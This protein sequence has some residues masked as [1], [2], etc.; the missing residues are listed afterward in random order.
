MD[1]RYY[2]PM[3]CES[4]G[5]VVKAVENPPPDNEPPPANDDDDDGKAD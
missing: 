1:V 4:L 2:G 3:K 5:T